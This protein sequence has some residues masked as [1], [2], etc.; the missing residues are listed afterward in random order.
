MEATFLIKDRILSAR[1][2]SFEPMSTSNKTKRPKNA[3]KNYCELPHFLRVRRE[4]YRRRSV[5]ITDFEVVSG[6]LLDHLTHTVLMLLLGK[7]VIE[8]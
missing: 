6:S 4:L 3:L 1:N 7:Q 5:I 8:A 2:V